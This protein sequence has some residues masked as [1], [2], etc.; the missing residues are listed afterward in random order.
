MGSRQSNSNALDA[1]GRLIESLGLML[2]DAGG[3]VEIFG[4]DPL[5]PSVAR[6]GEPA[7]FEQVSPSPQ[8]KRFP[9]FALKKC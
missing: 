1:L 5:F 9:V 7:L 8:L 2:N 6:L 4:A 3:G